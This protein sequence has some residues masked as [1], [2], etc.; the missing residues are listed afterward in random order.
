MTDLNQQIL[1][2]DPDSLAI[3]ADEDVQYDP[4]E[5]SAVVATEPLIIT[6]GRKKRK[7]A[8]REMSRLSPE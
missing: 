7:D 1:N 4:N 3:E 5:E 2:E 6:L 8:V